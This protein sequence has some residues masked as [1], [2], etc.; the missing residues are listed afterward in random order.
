[1]EPTLSEP[2]LATNV[3]ALL[4][5][6]TAAI[7]AVV[8]NAVRRL[9]Q[10]GL[11]AGGLVQRLG[12]RQS[13]GKHAVWLDDVT[14]GDTTRLD[15][16]RGPGARA[17][18]LDTGALAQ[19]AW[20]LRRAIDSKPDVVVISRFGSVEAEGGGLRAEIAEAVCSGAAVLIPVRESLLPDLEIF[21]GGIPA[22]LPSD[23][24]A[25]AAWGKA[26]V[27]RTKAA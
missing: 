26:M 17:C 27:A 19:G 20:M 7:Q 21:L 2:D 24:A 8:I 10:N 16:P 4:Y 5:T 13:N 11:T 14:T 23:P 6:D 25:I 3:A 9:R 12:E 18:I 22:V 15:E 1:M